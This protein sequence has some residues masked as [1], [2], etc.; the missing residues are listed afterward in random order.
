[1]LFLYLIIWVF[2]GFSSFVACRYWNDDVFFL[3]SII[4]F[5]FLLIFS[6]L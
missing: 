6:V 3:V 5:I 1:M 4:S 2:L